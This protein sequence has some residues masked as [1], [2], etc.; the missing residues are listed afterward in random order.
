MVHN[1]EEPVTERGEA[2]RGEPVVA[3]HVPEAA[4]S[5]VAI[6]PVELDQQ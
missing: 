5:L 1:G 3:A 4:G 6:P 2:A